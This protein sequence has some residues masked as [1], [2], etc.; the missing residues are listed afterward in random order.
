MVTTLDCGPYQ[1]GG[2]NASARRE[3]GAL[4]GPI[5]SNWLSEKSIYLVPQDANSPS[6][7]LCISV[8]AVQKK[9]VAMQSWSIGVADWS[10]LIRA[11]HSWAALVVRESW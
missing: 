1:L 10:L 2:I 11:V 4:F 9:N 8:P 5:L 7:D 6:L 3:L